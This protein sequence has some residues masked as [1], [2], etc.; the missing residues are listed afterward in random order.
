[1]N[2]EEAKQLARKIVSESPECRVTGLLDFGDGEYAI[3][4][5]DT[6]RKEQFNVLNEKDWFVRRE[7]KKKGLL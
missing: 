1:M 4:V 7:K 5:R 6:E 3:E 2:K